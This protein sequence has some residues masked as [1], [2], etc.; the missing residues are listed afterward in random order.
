[1][2]QSDRRRQALKIKSGAGDRI[3]WGVY[4]M[5]N[6]KHL[7]EPPSVFYLR[8]IEPVKR[9]T[10]AYREEAI[11]RAGMNPS[12]WTTKTSSSPTC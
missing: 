5:E 7:P 4:I 11:V 9:T 3:V 2:N 1:M 10:R 6:F 8:V 12:C